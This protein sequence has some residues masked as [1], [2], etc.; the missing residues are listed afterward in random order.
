MTQ[1]LIEH[2]ENKHKSET[3]VFF[4]SS[5]VLGAALSKRSGEA[6]GEGV[7]KVED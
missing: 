7:Q 1:Y 6:D 4:T 5:G 2:F 3:S